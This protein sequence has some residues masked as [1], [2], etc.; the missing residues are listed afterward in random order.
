MYRKLIPF[1][2]INAS[3]YL[4]GSCV[5]G[6]NTNSYGRLNDVDTFLVLHRHI[7][8]SDYL[9]AFAPLIKASSATDIPTSD[10]WASLLDGKTDLLRSSFLVDGIKISIHIF[11]Y[12]NL[13]TKLPDI[14][15]QYFNIIPASH[16]RLK[17][18]NA[19]AE[20]LGTTRRI[21]IDPTIV[22]M[23]EQYDLLEE[24]IFKETI[25]DDNST[26]YIKGALGDKLLLCQIQE[27]SAPIQD[28]TLLDAVFTRFVEL[29]KA[30]NSS[31]NIETILDSLARSSSFNAEFRQKMLTRLA[32]NAA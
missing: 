2:A 25:L 3:Y 12:T 21:S 10:R 31:A 11:R 28:K 19:R 4:F 29:S 23:T 27:S 30:N 1:H 16:T 18:T 13:A 5:Y 24:V 6:Y 20:I 32:Q 14:H 9:N 26:A 7:A 15:A 8:Y 17:E 22:P